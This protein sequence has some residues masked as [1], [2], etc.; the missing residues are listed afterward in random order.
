MEDPRR[1]LRFRCRGGRRKPNT[2]RA[3]RRAQGGR[4]RGAGSR[5][6]LGQWRFEVLARGRAVD[7][8]PTPDRW[9]GRHAP[10]IEQFRKLIAQGRAAGAVTGP[11]LAQIAN[12][13]RILLAR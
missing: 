3:P 1:W 12:Q 8:V 4:W 13:A 6:D 2:P 9:I 11:M 7:P 5:C 10:R